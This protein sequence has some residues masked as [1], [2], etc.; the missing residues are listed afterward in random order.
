MYW[1]RENWFWLV[2][3]VAFFWMHM[4]MH[5][6]HGHHGGHGHTKPSDR[7]TDREQEHDHAEH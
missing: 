3:F 1:L 2:V 7:P 4:N 6:G 5:A